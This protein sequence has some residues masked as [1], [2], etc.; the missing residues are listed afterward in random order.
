MF[1]LRIVSNARLLHVVAFLI[2]AI[3]LS[4]CFGTK[5]MP[6]FNGAIDTTRVDNVNIPDPVIQKGDQLSITVYSDNPEATAIFNQ[7]GGAPAAPSNTSGVSRTVNT[8][9]TGSGGASGYLVNIDGNILMHQLGLVK[10]EGLT[11]DQLA[12]NITAQL[13]T[14]GVLTNPYCVIRFSNFKITV[15]GEVKSPGVFTLPGEKASILEALGL[16]GD[17][18]DFGLKDKVMVIREN[19]G[20]RTYNNVNLLDPSTMQ[21]EFF[22]LKQNDLVL[23][24]PDKRKPTAL[25]LQS[26]QYI[27]I[28][29]TVV[30]SIAIILTLFR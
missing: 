14:L 2:A 21:S 4:S 16:A 23:V 18:T 5:P 30:S 27:T 29:A 8:S 7:A 22:Y 15:L 26:L 25:D 11:K 20:K 10:A 12:Q 6:Y 19:Q 24:Q 13:K 3:S 28:G 1:Y 9:T 17:I